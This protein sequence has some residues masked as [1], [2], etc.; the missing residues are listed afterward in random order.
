MHPNEEPCGEGMRILYHG[1]LYILRQEGDTPILM[2]VEAP[3]TPQ[4]RELPVQPVLA[5]RIVELMG[6]GKRLAL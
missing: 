5:L 3:F 1:D 6:K 2:R 4:V